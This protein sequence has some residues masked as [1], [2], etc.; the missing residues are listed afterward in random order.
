MSATGAGKEN[1]R[2]SGTEQP[3]RPLGTESEKERGS[4]KGGEAEEAVEEEQVEE[5]LVGVEAQQGQEAEEERIW[6]VSRC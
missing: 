5:L 4:V 6:G 3:C 1:G 2:G